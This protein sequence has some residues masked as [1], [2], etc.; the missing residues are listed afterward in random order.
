ME[1]NPI[2]IREAVEREMARGGQVFF[3]HNRVDNIDKVAR[4]LGM[5]VDDARIAVAHGQMNEMELENIIL[6]FWPENTM[7]SLVQPY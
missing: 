6:P 5:L 2:F 7:F 3:L 1:Y 4:D